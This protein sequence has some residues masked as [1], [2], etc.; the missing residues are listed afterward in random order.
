VAAAIAGNL[1]IVPLLESAEA[2]AIMSEACMVAREPMPPELR[3]MA[4]CILAKV[5]P[6]FAEPV[7][8]P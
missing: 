6:L 8:G 4:V 7:I 5:A 2:I 3:L 1:V